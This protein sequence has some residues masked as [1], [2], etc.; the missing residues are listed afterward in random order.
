LGG[1]S[2]LRP[3]L[4]LGP[5]LFRLSAIEL[6][7]TVALRVGI[8]HF[9]GSAA[10]I[11]LVVMGKIGEPFED[12]DMSSFQRPRRIFTLPARHCTLN[13]PNRVSLSPL[14]AAGCAVKP[15]S[16]RTR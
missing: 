8:E 2:R 15:L 14:S 10:G 5:Q 4:T 16:A 1:F 12:A 3:P 13:G 9:Q 11:D 7:D 6:K